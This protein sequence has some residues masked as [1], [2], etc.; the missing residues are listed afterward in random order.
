MKRRSES[1]LA[2]GFFTAVA[3]A[4]P[5]LAQAPAVTLDYKRY[6]SL[7]RAQKN[8]VAAYENIEQ[9]RKT[10]PILYSNHAQRAQELLI[11]ADKELRLAT[12]PPRRERK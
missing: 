10:Y 6:E 12:Q 11:E 2:A 3:F 9:G 7:W 1:I 8:I 4:V 5:L